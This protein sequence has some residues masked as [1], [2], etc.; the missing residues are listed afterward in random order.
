MKTIKETLLIHLSNTW[1]KLQLKS[2]RIW[3][4]ILSK[5]LCGGPTQSR[6]FDGVPCADV[7]FK[8]SFSL[9]SRSTPL[10]P[11]NMK[12]ARVDLIVNIQTKKRVGAQFTVKSYLVDTYYSDTIRYQR[13]TL[14]N[15]KC[16]S[17]LYGGLT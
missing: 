6:C 12:Y 13:S 5:R 17:I 3:V 8:S 2:T 1:L 10:Y 16:I 4:G 14:N 15:V 9:F 7:M 11:W